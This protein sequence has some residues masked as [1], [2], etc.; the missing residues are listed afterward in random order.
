MG[1]FPRPPLAFTVEPEITAGRRCFAVAQDLFSGS[2]VDVEVV[3]QVGWYDTSVHDELGSFACVPDDGTMDAL[4]G[5]IV[6]VSYATR[7]VFAYVLQAVA[8]PDGTQFALT[9]RTFMAIATPSAE[10]VAAKVVAV[11]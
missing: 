11:Q 6:R 1:N 2:P 7:E 10:V 9:R 8:L 4:I 3:L 5:E